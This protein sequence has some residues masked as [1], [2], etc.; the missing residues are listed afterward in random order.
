MKSVDLFCAS[1]ASTAIC[2][3]MDQRS[4]VRQRMRQ[5]ER[6]SHHR[7]GGRERP[8]ARTPVPCSSQIP[9]SPRPY[10]EKSRKSSSSKESELRRKSSADVTD[11]SPP[12]SSR[13]LLSDNPVF[14]LLSESDRASSALVPSQS[15]KIKHF[16]YDDFPV[17][18]SSS[19]R[20]HE[21]PVYKLPSSAR[22]NDLHAY[23]SP[24]SLPHSSDLNAKKASAASTVD[25][26][27]QKSLSLY[28]Q[29]SRDN[30]SSSTCYR[31]QV[32]D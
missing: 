23:K 19:A 10:F 1:P 18:R 29:H 31:E 17:F 12:R 14:E 24:L 5:I 27:A 7:L 9:I 28:K 32:L 25:S 22:P 8:K 26:H 3:S 11:L 13:Y 20:S 4:M 6:Q 30:K 2:S 15:V 16:N 21:S